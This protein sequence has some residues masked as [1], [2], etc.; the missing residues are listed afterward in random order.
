MFRNESDNES[1]FPR[2]DSPNPNL[3]FPEFPNSNSMN[4]ENDE[5]SEKLENENDNSK[6]YT[7]AITKEKTNNNLGNKRKRYEEDKEIKDLNEIEKTPNEFEEKK[8]EDLIKNEPFL[9]IFEKKNEELNISPQEQENIYKK[10]LKKKKPEEKFICH[11]K[12]R[13]DIT[14]KK[15]KKLFFHYIL[16][17]SNEILE[18]KGI[19]KKFRIPSHD[20]TKNVTIKSNK[21]ILTIDIKSLFCST[22]ENKSQIGDV[23]KKKIED[24]KSIFKNY[25]FL[26]KEYS[27][28][29]CSPLEN[30]LNDY[31]HSHEF[32]EDVRNVNAKCKNNPI[33]L[34]RIIGEGENNLINYLKFNNKYGKK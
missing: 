32:I 22:F 7:T 24:N 19:L 28:I 30:F 14:V 16:K 25:S 21:I 10:L 15:V 27:H 26:E 6:E 1:I 3:D 13:F 23:L 31:L 11:R 4:S 2:E 12:V 5:M 8:N 29:F 18:K 9:N 33:K 20:F 34:D 17:I